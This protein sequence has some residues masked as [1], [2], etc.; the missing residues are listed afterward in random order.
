MEKLTDPSGVIL[1]YLNPLTKHYEPYRG[2]PVAVSSGVLTV[3]QVVCRGPGM[4][5]DA[6]IYT[7]GANDV[8][9]ILY[10]NTSAAGKIL[11]QMTL[12][13]ANLSGGLPNPTPLRSDAGIYLSLTG[14]GGTAIVYYLP[15]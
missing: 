13:G 9:V 11:S 10:D 2:H 14:T 4:L 8:T 6:A 12:P 1:Y 7:N 3:S 5:M 15:D